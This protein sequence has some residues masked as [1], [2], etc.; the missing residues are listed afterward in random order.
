MF[1][2]FFPK[3]V[4]A[5]FTDG[6]MNF[7]LPEDATG[8]SNTQ[9]SYLSLQLRIDPQKIYTMRQ[10]HGHR[11][12]TVTQDSFPQQGDLPQ[13][14]AM[15]TNTPNIF[16][17]VRTADC[18]PIFIYDP[19]KR[20]IGLVHAGWRSTSENIARVTLWL[21]EKQ[22]RSSPSD[23]RVAFG[24]SIRP[25]CYEV[26]EEFKDVFPQDVVRK[27]LNLYLDV[28]GANKKQLIETGVKAENIFDVEL[29]TMCD[30]KFFSFR[31]D[32]EKAG[33]HLSLMSL[34]S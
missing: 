17:S 14:D 34:S 16:L 5:L 9:K 12:L 19:A 3:G 30:P 4:T 33:R 13:A 26:G 32:K 24:P 22:F 11:V 21:M 1:K 15:I 31:R 25:C 7:I 28:A 29:C 23:L 20:A 8:L 27:G 10:V 2:D 18:L 6:A